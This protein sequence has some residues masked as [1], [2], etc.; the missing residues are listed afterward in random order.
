MEAEKIQV[1]AK[2]ETR[3]N[4]N[5]QSEEAPFETTAHVFQTA[6]Y[7]AKTNR[8]LSDHESLIDLQQINGIE[9]GCMLHSRTAFLDALY[10]L[11]SQSPKNSCEL[12]AHANELHIVLQNIGKVFNLTWVASTWRAVNAVWQTYPASAKHFKAVSQDLSRVGSERIKFQGLHSKLCSVNFIRNLPLMLDVLTELKNLSDMLQERDKTI[13]KAENLM[14]IYIKRI[15]S[16]KT[17]PGIYSEEAQKAEQSMI[18]K[19]SKLNPRINSSQFIQAVIDDMR[20]KLFTTASNKADQSTCE[21]RVSNYK[22]LIIRTICR[23]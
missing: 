11:Y 14:Q 8:P 3:L 5:A 15:E 16:L 2:K 19:N 17:D 10:S 12:S 21:E 9:M 13:P 6:Y 18:F 1:M 22:N 7:I 4:L 20:T 23:F